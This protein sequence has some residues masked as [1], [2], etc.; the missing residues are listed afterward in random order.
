M[1]PWKTF[2]YFPSALSC[3]QGQSKFPVPGATLSEISV[4]YWGQD[5]TSLNIRLSEWKEIYFR[6]I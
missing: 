2:S 5:I 6:A 4:G 1:N 3:V